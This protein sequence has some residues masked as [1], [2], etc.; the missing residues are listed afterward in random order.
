VPCHLD[1]ARGSTADN[2]T[3]KDSRARTLC[4]KGIAA[5]GDDR[6]LDEAALDHLS[7]GDFSDH[8][9]RNHSR[10]GPITKT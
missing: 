10:F 4:E 5:W 1:E 6:L 8:P 7:M 2:Y 9:L 3:D